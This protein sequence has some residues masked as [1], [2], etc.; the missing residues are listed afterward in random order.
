M[1]AFS[2]KTWP[3]IA[4]LIEECGELSETLP[5]V[6]LSTVVGKITQTLG[7]LVMIQ[8]GTDHWSGDLR[9]AMIEEMADVQ[10]AL[11]FSWEQNLTKKER[12]M[13]ATRVKVKLRKFER[14]HKSSEVKKRIKQNQPKVKKTRSN[15]STTRKRTTK[16]A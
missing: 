7:K 6:I 15:A 3:G 5:L 12:H 13:I 1:F 11:I 14:W 8:G 2:D 10:A 9:K 16:R 4:K